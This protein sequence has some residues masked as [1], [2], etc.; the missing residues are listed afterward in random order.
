MTASDVKKLKEL[1]DENRRLKGVGK[2]EFLIKD[3]VVDLSLNYSIVKDAAS[4]NL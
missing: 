2:E 4:G 3:L 1:A